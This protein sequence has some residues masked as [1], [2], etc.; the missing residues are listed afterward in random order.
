MSRQYVYC[1]N[2]CSSDDYMTHFINCDSGISVF[3]N[4][5]NVFND[6]SCAWLMLVCCGNVNI[7][8]FIICDYKEDM[9]A[10]FHT[11]VEDNNNNERI[12]WL[13]LTDEWLTMN[14]LVL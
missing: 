1:Y 2:K 6:V 14:N 5:S 4:M 10:F 11:V 8:W 12:Y 13:L 9:F 7:G 3:L